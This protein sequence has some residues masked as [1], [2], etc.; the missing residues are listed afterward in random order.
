M[1]HIGAMRMV[2]IA[3]NTLA[4]KQNDKLQINSP[5]HSSSVRCVR[6]RCRLRTRVQREERWKWKG[7]QWVSRNANHQRRTHTHLSFFRFH[8]FRFVWFEFMLCSHS[9]FVPREANTFCTKSI[10][11]VSRQLGCDPN[12]LIHAHNC[13]MVFSLLLSFCAATNYRRIRIINILTFPFRSLIVCDT[14]KYPESIPSRLPFWQKHSKAKWN[15][16]QKKTLD[17]FL[18]QTQALR[19]HFVLWM[20]FYI[21]IFIKIEPQIPRS[22][23]EMVF[24]VHDHSI[25]K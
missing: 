15:W 20:E 3:N 5:F 17:I 9:L 23:E 8:S 13:S 2:N 16:K 4:S 24:T 25:C 1:G 22:T 12:R 11:I 10:G 18:R 6:N 21:I 19:C 14:T 7:H